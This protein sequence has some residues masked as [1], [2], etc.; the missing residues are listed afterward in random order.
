MNFRWKTFKIVASMKKWSTRESCMFTAAFHRYITHSI[1]VSGMESYEQW[2]KIYKQ[3]N[4]VKNRVKFRYTHQEVQV[5]HAVNFRKI[6][7]AVEA[8]RMIPP[9]SEL[10]ENGLESEKT[11][12]MKKFRIFRSFWTVY[13]LTNSDKVRTNYGENTFFSIFETDLKS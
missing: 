10:L 13:Y 7:F 11:I 1:P 6:C 3:K 9:F 2:M 5:L 12:N 8:E 4:H